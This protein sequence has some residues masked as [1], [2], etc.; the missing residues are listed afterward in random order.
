MSFLKSARCFNM[1]IINILPALA[2]RTGCSSYS[3]DSQA[4]LDAR[5]SYHFTAPAN[6]LNDPNGLVQLDGEYHLF[7]QYNPTRTAWGFIHRGHVVGTDL[8]H[9]TDLAVAAV[10]PL[11]G[12]S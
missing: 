12:S 10:R 6:W 4:G 9:W 8:V 7:Y 1:S 3:L 11:V 5:S 2:F